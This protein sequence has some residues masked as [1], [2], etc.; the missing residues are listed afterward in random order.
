MSNDFNR[1]ELPAIGIVRELEDDD[2]GLLSNYGEFLPVQEGEAVIT[3]GEPQDS[4]IFLISGLLHVTTET[5]GKPTLLARI[6][7]GA[8]IGEVNLFDPATASATVRAKTFSQ[9]WKARRNDLDDFLRAYPEA[10][11]RLLI[12]LLSEMSRRLRRMNDKVSNSELQNALQEF[13]K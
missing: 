11:G 13:F 6:E 5:A 2:R 3:E 12:G 4:L 8:T 7:A 9:I 10:A 1:P